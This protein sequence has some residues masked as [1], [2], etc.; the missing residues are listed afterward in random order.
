LVGV[1]E[2]SKVREQSCA[3]GG[4][5]CSREPVK[6]AAQ[7]VGGGDD[8]CAQSVDRGGLGLD[9][10][11]TGHAQHADRLDRSVS[12]L[13]RS[14]CLARQYGSSGGFCVDHVAFAAMPSQSTVRTR[15][16]EYLH[17]LLV[18]V[19]GQSGSV[20]AGPLDANLAQ[21]S[22]AAQPGQHRAV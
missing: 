14:T 1:V 3:G 8:H 9:G 6:L 18:Q 2:A 17:I 21:A 5:L 12:Q 16:F 19:T 15:H 11:Q 20:G 10:T 22:L 13:G 7:R 4:Q